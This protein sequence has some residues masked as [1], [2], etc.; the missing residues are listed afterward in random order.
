MNTSTNDLWLN[1]NNQ[2]LRAERLLEHCLLKLNKSEAERQQGLN[3]VAFELEQLLPPLIQLNEGI[4]IIIT[5]MSVDRQDNR[6]QRWQGQ[7]QQLL[8]PLDNGKQNLQELVEKLDQS[9]NSGKNLSNNSIPLQREE[10]KRNQLQELLALRQ[11][12]VLQLQAEV[13]ELQKQ[14]FECYGSSSKADQNK[15]ANPENYNINQMPTPKI[16]N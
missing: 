5:E 2:F 4:E 14:L 15:P 8:T 10:R 6:L 11:K 1:A 7:L 9:I 16:F 12:Q 3:K 13:S